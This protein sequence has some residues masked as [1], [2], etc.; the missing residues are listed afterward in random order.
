MLSSHAY[1][2]KLQ[3][4]NISYTMNNSLS[5]QPFWSN[6]IDGDFKKSTAV[7]S[8]KTLKISRF[9]FKGPW[10]FKKYG[11]F[12]FGV[13]KIHH[14]PS[15]EIFSWF[16]CQRNAFWVICSVFVLILLVQTASFMRC[17]INCKTI[18]VVPFS[19]IKDKPLF[20]VVQVPIRVPTT[21]GD[22]VTFV[23]TRPTKEWCVHVQWDWSL[24]VT[25]KPVLSLRRSFCLQVTMTLS[26]CR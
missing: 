10:F 13:W 3:K 12:P 21:M 23:C 22:A 26:A 15:W 17:W 18:A 24:S 20:F 19:W 14:V 25:G 1:Y 2:S 9:F 4:C 7:K 8:L 6:Y 5:S 11:S 16:W